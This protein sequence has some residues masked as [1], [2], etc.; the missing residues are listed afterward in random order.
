MR[1]RK[2]INSALSKTGYTIHRIYS[3]GEFNH[4]GLITGHNHDFIHDP[5]FQK[6]YQRGVQA[7]PVD[8]EIEWRCHIA[9]WA[10]FN[11]SK[12]PGDFVECGV[13]F[14]FLS[15][16]IMEYLD[17]NKI[18]KTFF[19]LDTFNGCDDG[20]LNDEERSVGHVS[21]RTK[22]YL[23]RGKYNSNVQNVVK[24]FST[25]KNVK[26]I[27]G[28]VPDTLDQVTTDRVAYLHLDMNCVVP[29]VAALKF[30]WPKLAPGAMIL[31]D[32]YGFDGHITQKQ[33]M[34]DC[35]S[36]FGTMVATLPTGQGLMIKP[37]I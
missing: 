10:A 21:A 35:A 24:N 6:A 27:Q 23:K 7:A 11:A 26:I 12:L 37:M 14:G 20:H 13:N 36:K 25:W 19:L 5:H 28:A 22:A 3:S 1:V 4:D 32:D 17:W 18:N 16:A 9:I 2:L 33:A 29:E 30:F 15:S 8:Y 34:D 31:L